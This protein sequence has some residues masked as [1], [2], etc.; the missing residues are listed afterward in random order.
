MLMEGAIYR[1][2]GKGTFVAK[3]K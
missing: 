2:Q 1:K 3:G